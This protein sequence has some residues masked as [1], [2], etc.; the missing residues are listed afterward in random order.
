MSRRPH[1]LDGCRTLALLTL[2]AVVVVAVPVVADDWPQWRGAVWHETGIVETLP[3]RAEGRVAHSYR[4][5][6]LGSRCRRRA[7][8]RV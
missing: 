3:G 2:A 4:V 7:C 8:L 5:R 6:L 1:R